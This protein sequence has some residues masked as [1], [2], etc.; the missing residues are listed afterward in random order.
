MAFCVVQQ[1]VSYICYSDT[2]HLFSK[3][4]FNFR[5]RL[6]MVEKCI[7]DWRHSGCVD[8]K[9]YIPGRIYFRENY[10]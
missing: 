8:K 4:I 1:M 6:G 5:N 10:Q 7:I 3:I 9:K 2:L